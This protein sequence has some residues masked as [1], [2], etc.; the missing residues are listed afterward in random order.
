MEQSGLRPQSSGS[1]AGP[2]LQVPRKDPCFP[3]VGSLPAAAAAPFKALLP[4][5]H[6]DGGGDTCGMKPEALLWRELRLGRPH[7]TGRGA[8]PGIQAGRNV[9]PGNGLGDPRG[10]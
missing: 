10:R 3:A 9:R 6:W 1:V 8:Q 5:G 4:G 7:S 2:G